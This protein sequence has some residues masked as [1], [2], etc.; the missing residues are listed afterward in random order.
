MVVLLDDIW[1]SMKE[2]ALKNKM[3]MMLVVR[4]AVVLQF[5]SKKWLVVVI[6]QQKKDT[7]Y[8]VHRLWFMHKKL[9]NSVSQIFKGLFALQRKEGDL[10]LYY[11]GK[12]CRD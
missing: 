5:G 12:R 11:R 6:D 9:L 4:K 10:G 3:I 7:S 1:E 2:S 8:I